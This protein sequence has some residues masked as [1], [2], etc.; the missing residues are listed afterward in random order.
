M[1]FTIDSPTR[2]EYMGSEQAPRPV[3]SG[4]RITHVFQVIDDDGQPEDLQYIEVM[5]VETWEH[6]TPTIDTLLT[7]TH[8][9]GWTVG[10]TV[11]PFDA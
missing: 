7:R 6:V 8:A 5:E 4:Y 2:Y 11:S 10:I 3:A 1:A 9:D